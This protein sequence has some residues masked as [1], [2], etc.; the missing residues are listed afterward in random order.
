M[1]PHVTGHMRRYEREEGKSRTPPVA[2]LRSADNFIVENCKTSD[3]GQFSLDVDVCFLE[4]TPRGV[5]VVLVCQLQHPA[6]GLCRAESEEFRVR[7]AQ[8]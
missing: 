8:L 7:T 6:V 3:N 2:Q 1:T 5:D 4:T